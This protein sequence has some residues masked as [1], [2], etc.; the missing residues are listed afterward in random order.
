MDDKMKNQN[1]VIA[2]KEQLSGDEENLVWEE[3]ST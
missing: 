2:A 1:R 3:I